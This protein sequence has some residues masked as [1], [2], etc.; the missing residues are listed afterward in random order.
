MIHAA[1]W[2]RPGLR[3]WVARVQPGR[4]TAQR[5]QTGLAAAACGRV[6]D[7]GRA[8]GGMFLQTGEEL[9]QPEPRECGSW[10]T[11]DTVHRSGERELHTPK[12]MKRWFMWKVLA[13]IE[14]FNREYH[15]SA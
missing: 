2:Q 6:D 12:D 15:L 10:M 11:L 13:G 1:E 5:V 9:I 3:V 4:P 7:G 14:G 8:L